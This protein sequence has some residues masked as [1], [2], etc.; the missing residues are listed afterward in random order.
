[1]MGIK[2]S[3]ALLCGAVSLI[4]QPEHVLG[5]GLSALNLAPA[6]YGSYQAGRGA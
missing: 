4:P 6:I 5:Y 1:M 3:V 2:L